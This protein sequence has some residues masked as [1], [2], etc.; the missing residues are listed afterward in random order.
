MDLSRNELTICWILN[1]VCAL[2]GAS[3]QLDTLREKNG[4]G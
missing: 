1:L 3:V 4:V 2:I